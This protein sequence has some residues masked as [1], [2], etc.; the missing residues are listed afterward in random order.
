MVKFKLRL[1][2]ACLTF[3]ESFKRN[4]TTFVVRCRIIVKLVKNK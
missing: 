3:Q 4:H 2:V 1:N